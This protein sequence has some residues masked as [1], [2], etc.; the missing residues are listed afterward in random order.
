[1]SENR[2]GASGLYMSEITVALSP[3]ETAVAVN[4]KDP[5]AGWVVSREKIGASG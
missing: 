4:W 2:R 1:M 5:G 3:T